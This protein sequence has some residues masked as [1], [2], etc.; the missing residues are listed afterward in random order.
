MDFGAK[1]ILIGGTS[2]AGET[3]KSIFTLLN[4][5]LPLKGVLSMHCSANIG[6][7]GDTA[8]FFGLSAQARPRSQPIPRES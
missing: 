6:K 1:L 5:L 3:K 7:A 4:Y 2:Y 8:I